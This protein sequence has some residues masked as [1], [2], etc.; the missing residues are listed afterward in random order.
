MVDGEADR[1]LEEGEAG[2]VGSRVE[3]AAWSGDPYRQ[4]TQ[5][6]LSASPSPTTTPPPQS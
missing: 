5:L 2:L 4:E 1:Q 3:V 6:M